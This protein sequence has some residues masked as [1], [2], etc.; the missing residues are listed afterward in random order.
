[1]PWLK[2][3]I[4]FHASLVTI[5][6]FI[7]GSLAG[8]VTWYNYQGNAATATASAQM[9]LQQIN[10]KIIESYQRTYDPIFGLTEILS[11]VPALHD[12]PTLEH[13]HPGLDYLMQTVLQYPQIFSLY[14]GYDNGDFVQLINLARQGPFRQSLQA[15]AT[16]H[17]GLMTILAGDG[18]Q[19]RKQ[20]VFLDRRGNMLTT[21]PLEATPFD[22]RQRPWFVKEKTDQELKVSNLYIY[23]SIKKPGI[24]ISRR[25][26]GELNNGVFGID[27]TLS[28]FSAFLQQQLFTPSNQII[29]FN[30]Q[31]DLIV[32]PQESKTIQVARDETTGQAT[33][34]TAKVTDLHD[35]VLDELVARFQQGL[36][37]NGTIFTVNGQDHISQITPVPERYGRETMIAVTV[38]LSEFLGPIA[39]TGIHSLLFS[40]CALLLALPI[41]LFISMRIASSLQQLAA[42]TSRIQQFHLTGPVAVHSFITEIRQLAQ[43][44]GAMKNALNIFGQYVP[45]VLVRQLIA[46]GE[47]IGLNSERREMTILFTDVANFTTLAETLP[48]EQLTAQVSLYLKE[49]TGII[50]AQGGTIDKYIGDAIMAFWNAPARMEQHTRQA[51]LATL[52]CA[53]A[54]NSL[55]QTWR[56]NNQPTLFTRF[57]LHTGDTI[58]GNIGSTDRMDYTAMGATVNLAS[59]IEGLNKVYGSQILVTE[60]V[61]QAIGPEFVT[62]P[63]DIAIPKGATRAVQLFELLGMEDGPE[64]LRVSERLREELRLWLPIYGDYQERQWQKALQGCQ[65]LLAHTPNSPLAILYQ[66]RCQF[67]IESPPS[68]DWN[69]AKVFKF[70]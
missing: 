13:P 23:H 44:I 51:C 46:T 63:V 62:R 66:Q 40:L 56:A 19:P 16:T 1:M 65:A 64:A 5:F 29:L 10:Q 54:S 49:L 43:S 39:Q 26:G 68:E 7:I 32:H 21:T 24:T 20:W 31:G 8:S 42:E 53:V 58:V 14:V 69:G 36:W 45:K 2:N 59:R 3:G 33:L 12:H 70:K 35:P 4:S 67:F 50:H 28:H 18:E 22:P 34:K 9:L 55:N 15:P 37:K 47:R 6:L 38:P 25:L 57:G 41:I 60:A 61:V 11:T 17:F 52:T 30:R 48:P 27:I